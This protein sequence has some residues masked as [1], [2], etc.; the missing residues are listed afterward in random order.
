MFP[1]KEG[2]LPEPHRVAIIGGSV[3][4]FLGA[5]INHRSQIYPHLLDTKHNKALLIVTKNV[6]MMSTKTAIK[7]SWVVPIPISVLGMHQ[8]LPRVPIQYYVIYL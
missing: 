1:S 2:L 4:G 5:Q 3:A 8:R 6:L 7:A